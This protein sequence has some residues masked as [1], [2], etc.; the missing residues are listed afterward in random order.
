M[1]V[2]L[3]SICDATICIINCGFKGDLS[4]TWCLLGKFCVQRKFHLHSSK[5]KK[6]KEVF[7]V[8]Y[9]SDQHV[10]CRLLTDFS[11]NLNVA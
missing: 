4:R 6:K 7:H 8:L 9:Q 5:S 11:L 10:L 3:S 2:Y 1:V